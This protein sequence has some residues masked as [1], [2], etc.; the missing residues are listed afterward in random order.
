MHEVPHFP[1]LLYP[2]EKDLLIHAVVANSLQRT[3]SCR[4]FSNEIDQEVT[5]SRWRVPQ[6]TRYRVYEF[7]STGTSCL[8][9][10]DGN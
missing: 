5:V 1:I 7:G 8:S 6:D 2:D 10:N 4:T 3:K 9:R